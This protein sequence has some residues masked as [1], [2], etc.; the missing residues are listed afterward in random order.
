MERINWQLSSLGLLLL[1]GIGW[2]FLDD[3]FQLLKRGRNRR[4]WDIIFWPVS[5]V[6]LAPVIFFINW[7]ELRLYVWITL[8]IGFYI[9]RK[10]FHL[11]VLMLFK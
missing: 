10:L 5:L 3:C 8:G 2:G 7:G 11:S 4:V 1:A 9:Y 6:L